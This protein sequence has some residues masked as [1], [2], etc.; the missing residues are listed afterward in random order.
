MSS[1]VMRLE[2]GGMVQIRT[3]VIQGIGPQGPPGATGERG[4]TGPAGP[5]GIPGPTG[6]VEEFS[7]LFVAT[8]QPIATSTITSNYP[9]TWTAVAYPTVTRDEL[10]LQQ[11]TTNYFLPAGAD[12]NIMARIRFVKQSATN[13]TGYRGIQLVYNSV[14]VWDEIVSAV[15]L[16]DTIVTLRAG[17][18][19][20]VGTDVLQVKVSH[21]EPAT[22]NVTGTLWINRTGPGIQGPQG[23]QGI[24]GPQGEDGPQ[25]PIGPEGSLVTSTTTIADIGGTN[26]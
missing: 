18:R 6:G 19:S 15:S 14:N 1:S 2:S 26:P 9:T 13:A 3:G 23:L 4:E 17:V 12:Y 20:I 11:S 10:D 25:G 7:G 8:S 5:Q 21:N 16:T 24:Q 22:I